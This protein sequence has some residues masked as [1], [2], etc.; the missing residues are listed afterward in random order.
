LFIY[1]ALFDCGAC[2]APILAASSIDAMISP[3]GRHQRART[4]ARTATSVRLRI[5]ALACGTAIVAAGCVQPSTPQADAPED[6]KPV[7]TADQAAIA[8]YVKEA[9]ALCATA[10]TKMAANLGAFEVHKSVTG[11]AR[12]KTIRLAK[13]D[14]VSAYIKGQL[15]HLEEQQ[16]A[17]RKLEL[18]EGASGEQLDA[19]WTKAEAVMASI[20]KNPDQV[21]YDDPFK[22]VADALGDLGFDQCFQASRPDEAEAEG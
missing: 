12:R 7:L 15:I 11:S 22:E 3:F 5:A 18:P 20:K 1:R 9:D 13:P 21:A 10:R 6:T 2:I 14:E 19:L 8:P 17:V 4:A 16:V